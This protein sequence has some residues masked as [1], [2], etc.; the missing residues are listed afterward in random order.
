MCDP[1]ETPTIVLMFRVQRW[2]AWSILALVGVAAS[3]FIGAISEL[4][5]LIAACLVLAAIVLLTVALW[6]LVW[7]NATQA[8]GRL[9]GIMHLFLVVLLTPVALVGLFTIPSL[10]FSD[11]SRWQDWEASRTSDAPSDRSP[12]IS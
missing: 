4:V 3:A 12:G 9:Y 7:R 10:V 11:I 2:L 8:G 1:A 5:Y 6:Y